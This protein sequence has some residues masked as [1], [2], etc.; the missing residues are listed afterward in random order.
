MR[1]T[2]KQYTLFILNF[3]VNYLTCAIID[4]EYNSGMTLLSPQTHFDYAI[5]L[6]SLICLFLIQYNCYNTFHLWDKTSKPEGIPGV[7]ER[8]KYIFIFVAYI[9]QA[10]WCTAALQIIFGLGETILHPSSRK[11]YLSVFIVLIFSL[12]LTI[13]RFILYFKPQMHAIFKKV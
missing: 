13:I 4:V 2:F 1:H 7:R 5:V 12:T 8:I 9:I 11:D 3:F 6:F 10:Y